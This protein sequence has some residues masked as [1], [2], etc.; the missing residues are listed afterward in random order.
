M[1]I[2]CPNCPTRLKIDEKILKEGKKFKC[3]KCGNVST[4]SQD[5]I[6]EIEEV[7]KK[8][9]VTL[10]SLPKKESGSIPKDLRISVS[11]IEGNDEGKTIQLGNPRT[12]LGRETADIILNDPEV[13]RTH[14]A[15]LI[16]QKR[17]T[18]K[19]LDSTNGTFVNGKK[20]EEGDLKHLDEIEIGGTRLLFTVYQELEEFSQEFYEEESME[21]I[22][23]IDEIGAADDSVTRMERRDVDLK[24]PTGRSLS[25]VTLEGKNKGERIEF[26]K[27]RII[28]GRTGVDINLDDPNASRKHAV[29]EAW[30]RDQIYLRDLASTNGTF[31]NGAR[32]T[33][34]RLNNGDE[35]V[36]GSTRLRFVM[37]MS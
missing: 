4:I 24:L 13:S 27:G 16:H 2:Q 21:E 30:S 37:E 22:E 3:P 34:A 28:I 23:L 20:I 12:T 31:L 29:I 25:L 19:D 1:F 17:F 10:H 5:L 9:D 7:P 36:I 32:I 33:S 14:T 18:I 8:K 15:I 6:G 11:I 26:P 35:I